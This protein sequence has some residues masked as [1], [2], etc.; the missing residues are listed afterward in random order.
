M[1][2]TAVRPVAESAATLLVI[3]DDP[4]TAGLLRSWFESQD[5]NVLASE[6]ADA[7]LPLAQRRLPDLILLDVRM[8]GIDGLAATRKLKADPATKSIPVILLTACRDVEDKV[9][10]FSAGADDYITKPFDFEEVDARIRAMLRKRELY[11][12]LEQTVEHLATTNRQLE[13]LLIVDEKTGLATFRHFERKLVEEWL[14]AERYGTTLSL[15]MLDIDDFK[16]LNDTL[17]HQAGDIALRE[18]A[19]LIAGGARA[20][21][22]AARYGGEEFAVLLPHT[23]SEMASRVAE[24]I[25]AAVSDFIFIDEVSPQRLTI[26]AG[27]ATHTVA[28]PAAS[29]KAF[30]E[31]ADQALYRAKKAGKNRVVIAD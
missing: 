26:S 7:G 24:R 18:L 14:R 27:I 21:D 8:P 13:E 15:V 9:E 23:D 12:E 29:S 3:D 4:Q 16:Q 19:T 10:A 25:R 20:T 30:V 22:I 2:A 17:G 1:E 5:F 6:S 31:L 11:V 28:A